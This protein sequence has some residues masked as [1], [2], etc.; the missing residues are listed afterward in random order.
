VAE[1]RGTRKKSVATHS[2]EKMELLEPE[3]KRTSTVRKK[4]KKKKRPGLLVDP[5]SHG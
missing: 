5:W 3:R 4:R 1:K 2:T